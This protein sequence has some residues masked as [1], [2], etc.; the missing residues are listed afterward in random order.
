[1]SCAGLQTGLQSLFQAQAVGGELGDGRLKFAADRRR[2]RRLLGRMLRHAGELLVNR[3]AATGGALQRGGGQGIR[4]VGG[5]HTRVGAGQFAFRSGQNL[6]PV[7]VQDQPAT[8]QI[9]EVP[10]LG[11]VWNVTLEEHG[12]MTER[13]QSPDQGAPQH[14]VAV[15]PGGAD[16]ETEDYEF[17][18]N[19]SPLFRGGDSAR[20]TASQQLFDIAFEGYGSVSRRVLRQHRELRPR[21]H[22]L[23]DYLEARVMPKIVGPVG[24]GE[25]QYP[26][27]FKA[28][29]RMTVSQDGAQL[30]AWPVSTG[31]RGYDTP[32]GD[33]KPFRMEKTHFSR[34]WDD[35]PWE[36]RKNGV[37]GTLPPGQQRPLL[38]DGSPQSGDLPF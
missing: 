33:F 34:E 37:H 2:C 14:G 21:G 31:Q 12:V 3:D 32:S 16:R 5:D 11:V 17:H 19:A 38:G 27:I 7:L 24:P 20:L 36:Q 35:A 9:G 23:H 28:A 8:L 29:Q 1:M 13:A 10:V 4:A 22:I 30:H 6:V 18:A 26:E 25:M 15:T